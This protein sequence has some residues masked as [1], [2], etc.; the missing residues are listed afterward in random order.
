MGRKKKRDE[1]AGKRRRERVAQN[2]FNLSF[3]YRC[4]DFVFTNPSG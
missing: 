4:P 3:V 2:S 1:E